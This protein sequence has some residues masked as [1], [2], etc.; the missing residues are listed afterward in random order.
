MFSATR[1]ML[2]NP[3]SRVLLVS[4]VSMVAVGTVVY[5]FLEGW[6]VVDA[7]YFSVVALATV[8]FGDLTPTTEL[9]KLFTVA[10]IIS[11]LGILGAFITELG[12]QRS[13]ARRRR[14]TGDD[15]S[16]DA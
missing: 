10:Y 5:M 14:R 13:H 6:S 12:K 8:G 11:G 2:G 15:A 9:A 1:A 16:D 3:E 4:A 7:L